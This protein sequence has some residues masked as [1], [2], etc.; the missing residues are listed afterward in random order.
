MKLAALAKPFAALAVAAALISII[1]LALGASPISAFEAL[2]EVSMPAGSAQ[3]LAS[4]FLGGE[5]G[6]T[7]QDA[8]MAA[9]AAGELCNIIAGGWK[10][11]LSG[12]AHLADLSV[13]AVVRL[14]AGER[15]CEALRVNRVYIFGAEWF[16]VRLKAY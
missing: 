5:S 3:R 4:I 12:D 11:R 10:R 1:L 2:C 9:D 15:T 14:D 6:D 13:P 8:A 7:A 16:E